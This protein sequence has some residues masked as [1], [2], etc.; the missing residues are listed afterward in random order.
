MFYP[1]LH[2]SY[3]ACALTYQGLLIT[4]S[5]NQFNNSVVLVYDINNKNCHLTN[6]IKAS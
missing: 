6:V 1:N 4:F 5:Q 2:T 3:P